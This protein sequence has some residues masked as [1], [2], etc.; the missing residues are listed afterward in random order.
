MRAIDLED[1][2]TSKQAKV[3]SGRER[4][5]YWRKH[6]GIDELDSSDEEV[7]V[8]IPRDVFSINLSFFLSLFGESVRRLGKEEFQKK[9]KFQCDPLLKPLIDQGIEQAT[10]TSSVFARAG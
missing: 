1:A 5:K 3:F 7:L 8:K 4:G 9:Y 10:K 6:F 2:R